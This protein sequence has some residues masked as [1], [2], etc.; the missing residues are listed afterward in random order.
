MTDDKIRALGLMSGGLDS[1][2]AANLMQTWGSRSSACTSRRA[3]VLPI[4]I[5]CWATQQPGQA[6]P[7]RRFAR[8]C[9]AGSPSRDHR[10][11]GSL[12]AGSRAE[13]EARVRLW[14][15]P[16]HRLP[17]LHA[18]AGE[19]D[20][21]GTGLRLH[22]HRRGPRD[23]RPMSQRR[24]PMQAIEIE[25]DLQGRYCCGRSPLRS[26]QS[27]FQKRKDGSTGTSC[28]GS[29]AA[30]ATSKC[31]S[32]RSSDS[33]ITHSRLAAVVFCPTRTTRASCAT[34]LTHNGPDVRP[35][36]HDAAEDRPPLPSCRRR[37]DHRRVGMSRRMI[38]SS[39]SSEGRG[40]VWL[41]AFSSPLTLI[42][43]PTLCGR[44]GVCLPDHGSL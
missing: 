30:V 7:Q 31:N 28:T 14:H 34:L 38:S 1:T 18:E 33:P 20:H 10:H 4:A 42:E 37:Q 2:L 43:G 9:P 27:P 3:S 5:A 8:G 19:G 15:E 24:P 36:R 25:A 41:E 39:A 6:L 32:P 26:C 23:R 13:P 12:P 40:S 35:R 44:P 11:Q 16:L 29:S 22:L 21:G 17:R